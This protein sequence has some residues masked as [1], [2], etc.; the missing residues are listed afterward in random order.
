MIHRLL[1]VY[2]SLHVKYNVHCIHIDTEHHILL[3]NA[4][5]YVES[6]INAYFERPLFL[7]VFSFEINCHGTFHGNFHYSLLFA[8]IHWNL[9]LFFS[10]QYKWCIRFRYYLIAHAWVTPSYWH[11]IIRGKRRA[12]SKHGVTCFFY[13]YIYIYFFSSLLARNKWESIIRRRKE[14]KRNCAWSRNV[15]PLPL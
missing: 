4:E 7:L 14:I 9:L 1:I 13:E 3:I 11:L 5:L 2:M 12:K 6:K 8:Y 10:Y 15:L